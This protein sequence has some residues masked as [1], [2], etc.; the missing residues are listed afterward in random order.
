MSRPEENPLGKSK[1]SLLSSANNPVTDNNRILASLEENNKLFDNANHKTSKRSI[2]L[3]IALGT[4][5]LLLMAGLWAMYENATS[6]VQR[7]TE[8]VKRDAQIAPTAVLRPISPDDSDK[9]SSSKLEPSNQAATIVDEPDPQT[10][11]SSTRSP[12]NNMQEILSA[13]PEPDA[14]KK[15]LEAKPATSVNTNNIAVT[16]ATESD[17][18]EKSIPAITGAK[19]IQKNAS[20]IAATPTG[21][22]PSAK[23]VADPDVTLLT[24][25]VAHTHTTTQTDSTQA[26]HLTNTKTQP[27]SSGEEN[28]TASNK[29]KPVA[30]K[31]TDVTADLLQQCKKLGLAE[32]ELCRWRIC[33]GRWDSDS[34]CK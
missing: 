13:T 19:T 12:H 22:P 11:M 3:K 31:E 14:L 20:K 33:S 25:L 9:Q 15:A 27:A 32:A 16:H 30:R 23:S 8:L 18:R 7:P 5:L 29:L 10:K 28:A 17:K 4:L 2:A 1:P 26:K 6:P 34:A 21:N 24:A